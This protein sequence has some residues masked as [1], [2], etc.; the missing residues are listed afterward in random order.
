M[1][2]SE[3]KITW[4]E[5]YLC[6][7]KQLDV[8]YKD[9]EI[10]KCRSCSFVFYKPIPSDH[11]L[12]V[13]YSK[14]TREQ[15]ITED[16]RIK[17]KSE[18]RHILEKFQIKKVLDIAC[19]ECY[20]L[21]ILREL[22]ASIS[23]NGTEHESAIQNFVNKDINYI[24][25]GFYPETDEKYDL[26]IFTEAIEHIND[27]NNF[28]KNIQR[29]L[30]KDGVIYITT[31]NFNSIERYLMQSKWGMVMPPEHL[32]YFTPRTLD[33]VMN[34]NGLKKVYLKTENISIFR[35][36][37][38]FNKRNKN[39]GLSSKASPQD[40]SD[41]V[42]R[43]V[44]KNLFLNVVKSSINILLRLSKSG[45]SIKALYCFKNDN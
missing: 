40:I 9:Y 4:E 13:V 25:G 34:D 21:E 16:S 37:E 26:I 24:E 43:A 6:S 22:D 33:K 23:L 27:V 32:S 29:L 35:I 1:I 42:Q 2:T 17:I 10:Y 31:P 41:K 28:L 18:F 30:S 20:M 14:Y 36:M 19:G 12:D 3:R 8:K 44:N 7:S 11:D 15:Y 38:F 39:K 5:C 45:S